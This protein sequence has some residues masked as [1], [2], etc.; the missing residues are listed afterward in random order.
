ALH[1]VFFSFLPLILASFPAS[2]TA[3]TVKSDFAPNACLE[4]SGGMPLPAKLLQLG[5][6]KGTNSQKFSFREDGRIQFGS[7]C[8]DAFSGLGRNGDVIM[9]WYCQGS[10]NQIWKRSLKGELSGI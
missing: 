6:C 3:A 7:L 10:A 8:V 2:A 9:L 5:A 4:V 1:Q